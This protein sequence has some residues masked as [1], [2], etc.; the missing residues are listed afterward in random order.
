MLTRIIEKIVVQHF[1][2][3][4]F[5]AELP[6]LTFADQLTLLA[7]FRPS[8]STTAA[9]IYILHTVFQIFSTNPYVIITEA[10]CNS[11][12]TSNVGLKSHTGF[13]LVQTDMWILDDLERRNGPYFA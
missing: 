2:Y 5:Q 4:A 12:E 7:E 13:R 1:L 10:N 8:G 6:Q 9:L 3:P 11:R